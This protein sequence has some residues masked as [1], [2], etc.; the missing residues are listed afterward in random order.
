MILS[1]VS[2]AG[3][4]ELGLTPYAGSDFP[5]MIGAGATYTLPKRV[6]LDGAAGVLP[7]PYWDAVNSALV[8]FEVYSEETAEL[9]DIL[10]TGALVLRLEAGWQPWEHR[11]F[12]FTAG[13]Q[14]L[15]LAGGST[16]IALYTDGLTAA[17]YESASAMFGDLEVVVVPSM[18]TGRTGWEWHVRENVLL[19]VTLGFAYTVH[20]RSE[21]RTTD[22]PTNPIASTLG[23]TL[24]GEAEA[25]LDD[26]FVSWVHTP[27]IGLY[28]GY[29]F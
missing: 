7:G 21:V 8:S 15:G 2:I 6:R 4:G 25:Y 27:M 11:G 29:R 12:F 20:S 22:P 13:Y 17:L 5:L 10:L 1:L 24:S 28:T 19:R 26:I 3:A 14:H 18:I 9:I 23:E 16:N